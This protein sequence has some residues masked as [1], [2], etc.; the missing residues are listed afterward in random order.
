MNAG[1]IVPQ[2]VLPY[3]PHTHCA[4]T[5]NGKL[6]KVLLKELE[7]RLDLKIRYGAILREQC[8][9]YGIAQELP[10]CPEVRTS[11]QYLGTDTQRLYSL[12]QTKEPITPREIHQ[13]VAKSARF[14]ADGR[15]L[16]HFANRFKPEQMPFE[17]IIGAG[18]HY[19]YQGETL[20]PTVV[21]VENGWVLKALKFPE[22][23]PDNN[24]AF[25]TWN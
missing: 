9:F 21:P 14:A 15:F 2:T 4:I 23:A 7:P 8:K 3:G 19:T 12:M 24:I 11:V 25:L 16:L 1:Q 13:E 18:G 10:P 22:I 20:Y 17:M 6:Y 5:Q